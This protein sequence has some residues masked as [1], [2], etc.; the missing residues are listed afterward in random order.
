MRLFDFDL[1]EI[2]LCRGIFIRYD[3]CN[4]IGFFSF[5]SFFFLIHPRGRNREVTTS[6]QRD[7][8]TKH[9]GKF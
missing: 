1:F 6:P 3:R 2:V 8:K 7:K 5:S 9:C 4:D